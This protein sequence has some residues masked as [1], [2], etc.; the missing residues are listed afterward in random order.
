MRSRGIKRMRRRKDID[1]RRGGIEVL[2]LGLKLGVGGYVVAYVVAYSRGVGSALGLE[3][4]IFL[5]NRD[6]PLMN[7]TIAICQ[8]YINLTIRVCMFLYLGIIIRPGRM[9]L[10]FL[11]YPVNSLYHDS[12]QWQTCPNSLN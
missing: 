2:G 3:F 12:P 9:V 4:G 6:N 7:N 10:C 5:K 8:S 1:R 11:R